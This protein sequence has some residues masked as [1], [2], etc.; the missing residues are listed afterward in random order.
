ML[1]RESTKKEI[2][3]ALDGSII[4]KFG[5]D[6][7]FPDETN[8]SSYLSNY[9]MAT[10]IADENYY[11]KISEKYNSDKKKNVFQLTYAPGIYLKDEETIHVD[12]F[13]DTIRQLRQWISRLIEDIRDR[14]PLLNKIYEE[15]NRIEEEFEQKINEKFDKSD[16]SY[17]NTDEISHL[18]E[19]IDSLY[20]QFEKL[21]EEHEIKDSELKSIKS[22][23]EKLKTTLPI[24]PKRAWYK[25]SG[26]KII[27]L[28]GKYLN[29]DTVKSIATEVVKGL[30][31]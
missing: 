12:D 25:S 16:K 23:L 9:F 5:F 11:F 31:N 15:I 22:E 3:S 30:L 21:K 17:F 20:S 4:G 2:L 29:P 1:F 24:L 7:H 28:I 13:A 8:Q 18:K 26:K 14:S 27:H 6:I 10:Y 19:R